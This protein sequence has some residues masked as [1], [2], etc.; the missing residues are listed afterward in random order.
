MSIPKKIIMSEIKTKINDLL[1]HGE[2]EKALELLDEALLSSGS[3]LHNDLVILKNEF[4]ALNQQIRTH[5]ISETKAQRGKNKI[6]ASILELAEMSTTTTHNPAPAPQKKNMPP[7]V[8]GMLLLLLVAAISWYLIPSKEDPSEAFQTPEIEKLVSQDLGLTIYPDYE[9]VYLH[10]KSDKWYNVRTSTKKL[11]D[12]LKAVGDDKLQL[13]SRI[14]KYL[15]LLISYNILATTS[16][17][18]NERISY[19]K[20]AIECATL[21][22]EATKEVPNIKD[23]AYQKKVRDWIY[24]KDDNKYTNIIENKL[25]AFAVNNRAGGDIKE[26]DIKDL[27]RDL[28][29]DNIL[30]ADGY[31]LYPIVQWL[32]STKIINLNRK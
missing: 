18:D 1:S 28:A 6:N 4:E 11:I 27:Y 17:E 10:G 8:L 21:A 22:E 32:D 20:Q 13:P 9:D 30:V 14:Y 23:V 2:T 7:W 16:Q 29:E 31:D 25:I 26:K 3:R 24:D 19:S 15:G 5:T 12:D